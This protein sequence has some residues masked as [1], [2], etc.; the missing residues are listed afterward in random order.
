MDTIKIQK[1]H[2]DK[3]NYYK[4]DGIGIWDSYENT[5]VEIDENLGYVKFKKGVYV[6]G[7]IICKAGSGI[8][9]GEGI[10]AG[11]GIMVG[12]GIMAGLGIMAGSGIKAGSG[13]EAGEGIMAGSGIM[14]GEGIKAGSGIMAG[15]G[16]KAGWGIEAGW[17]I[18]EHGNDKDLVD[19]PSKEKPECECCKIPN[20][21]PKNCLCCYY[22]TPEKTGWRIKIIKLCEKGSTGELLKLVESLLSDQK[23]ALI[24]KLDDLQR[25]INSKRDL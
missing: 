14:A 3:D 21:N 15:E 22:H 23:E 6:N 16:I 20:H 17:S 9:A 19:V 18:M 10:E 5:N 13:I 7:S 11:L 25:Q 4:E 24:K 8:E 1:K 2:L 12:E